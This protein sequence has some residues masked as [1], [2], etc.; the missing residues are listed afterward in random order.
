MEQTCGF[1]V[2]N[3]RTCYLH[4]CFSVF[5]PFSAQFY[6]PLH[7]NGKGSIANGHLLQDCTIWLGGTFTVDECLRYKA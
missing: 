2:Q 6:P 1:L 4:V 5:S 3:I 7:H